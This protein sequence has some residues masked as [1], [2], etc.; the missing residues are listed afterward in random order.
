VLY[1]SSEPHLF[2]K[3]IRESLELVRLGLAKG[4]LDGSGGDLLSDGPQVQISVLVLTQ[5]HSSSLNHY[6]F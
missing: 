5:F 6:H 2:V 3:L 4:F 1:E